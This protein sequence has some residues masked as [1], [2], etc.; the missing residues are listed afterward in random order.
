M[1]NTLLFVVLVFAMGVAAAYAAANEKDEMG[2]LLARWIVEHQARLAN[3]ALPRANAAFV[4]RTERFVIWR[5]HGSTPI[6]RNAKEKHHCIIFCKRN[7]SFYLKG[8]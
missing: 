7:I 3:S 5:G 6:K 1:G 8:V 4:N 2:P